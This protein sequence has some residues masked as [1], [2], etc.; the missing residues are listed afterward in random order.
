MFGASPWEGPKVIDGRVDV[1]VNRRPFY[2]GPVSG[3]MARGFWGAPLQL[4]IRDN[5]DIF[6]RIETPVMQPATSLRFTFHGWRRE[7]VGR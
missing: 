4:E 3:L 2:E 7:P 6:V 1:R 5:D